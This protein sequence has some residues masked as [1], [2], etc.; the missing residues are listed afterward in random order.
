[1]LTVKKILKKILKGGN[2]FLTGGA[3]VGKSYTINEIQRE[4]YTKTIALTALT[5]LA[6]VNIGGQTL[7]S[8]LNLGLC[9][10]NNI[11]QEALHVSY[12]ILAYV[13]FLSE[14]ILLVS[15][16]CYM[17][18][19]NYF[20]AI[21]IVLLG[22]I[23]TLFIKSMIFKRVGIYADEREKNIKDIYQLIHK[24]F[25]NFIFIKLVNQSKDFIVNRSDTLSK[26]YAN[27]FINMNI[28]GIFPKIIYEL[29]AFILFLVLL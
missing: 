5:G 25:N 10:S 9:K 13:V 11:T 1:M 8:F 22:L 14:I 17:L 6:A 12:V 16:F 2:I 21:I 28:L 23:V 27:K 7:H 29:V 24:T 19:I 20:I 3:G 26:Q 4:L 18:Y 15:I